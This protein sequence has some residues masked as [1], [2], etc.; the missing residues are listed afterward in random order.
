MAAL[1]RIWQNDYFRFHTWHQRDSNSYSY[2]FGVGHTNGTCIYTVWLNWEETGSWK[3]KMAAYTHKMRIF[4]LPD[5]NESDT[6][7]KYYKVFTQ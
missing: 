1:N 3:S 6:M 2:V 4:Q 5:W 7:L